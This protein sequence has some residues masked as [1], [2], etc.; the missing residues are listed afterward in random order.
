MNEL[1]LLADVAKTQPYAAYAA[2]VH[3]YVHKFNYLC[4]TVPNVEHSLEDQIRSHLIPT[5]TGQSTPN[6]SIRDLLCLPV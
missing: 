5:L 3:G 2:F 6:D 4:R 1:S